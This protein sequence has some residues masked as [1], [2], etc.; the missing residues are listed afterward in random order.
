M[1]K[2]LIAGSVMLL[3]CSGDTP[4]AMCTA[5]SGYGAASIVS[6]GSAY[7]FTATQIAEDEST[8]LID[9]N[10]GF[11]GNINADATPDMFEID[12]YE[13]FGTFMGSGGYITTGT[14]TLAGPDLSFQNCGL[15]VQLYTDLGSDGSPTD[16]YFATGGTVTLTSVGTPTGSDVSTGTLAG[17]VSNVAFAHWDGS[18]DAA[19]GDCSSKIDSL[20]FSASLTPLGADGSGAV[21]RRMLAHRRP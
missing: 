3:A 9:S 7:A 2:L 1:A 21:R 16:L 12:L 5:S 11:A 18:N 4:N 15:C 6:N 10:Q 17:T 13:G 20:Q 19:V 8:G 14:F